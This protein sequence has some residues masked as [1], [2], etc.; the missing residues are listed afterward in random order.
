MPKY[1]PRH[2]MLPQL[3]LLSANFPIVSGSYYE[4]MGDS[5]SPEQISWYSDEQM[6]ELLEPIV[7]KCFAD[8]KAIAK[9]AN[10]AMA[11]GDA[12]E[13]IPGLFFDLLEDYCDGSQASQFDAAL[14]DFHKCSGINMKVSLEICV[15][16]GVEIL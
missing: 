14:D 6:A 10:Q 12:L 5:S 4:D 2:L 8:D 13:M 7:S 9:I 11:G 1:L 16:A 15:D 3:L